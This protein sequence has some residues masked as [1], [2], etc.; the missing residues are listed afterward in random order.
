MNKLNAEVK[1]SSISNSLYDFILDPDTQE[2]YLVSMPS[3]FRKSFWIKRGDFVI[4]ENIAE[5]EKVKGEIV[6]I[7]SGDHMKEFSRAGVWPKAFQN[8]REHD[9]DDCDITDADDCNPNRKF[10]S[11]LT[12]KEHSS[13]TSESE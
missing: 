8:K 4:V 10:S 13:S 3:K 2:S 9:S 6:R 11:R 1:C 5:G 12:E 7:L